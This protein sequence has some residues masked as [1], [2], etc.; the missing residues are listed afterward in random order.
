MEPSRLLNHIEN[1]ELVRRL[2][3]SS[4]WLDC[5]DWAAWGECSVSCTKNKCHKT[6]YAS[7]KG[8]EPWMI[9]HIWGIDDDLPR[10]RM[11]C[12][13]K[14]DQRWHPWFIR[15]FQLNAAARDWSKL[16]INPLPTLILP[17]YV[18]TSIRI[19]RNAIFSLFSLFA[20]ANILN[21]KLQHELL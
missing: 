13:P 5:A 8:A 21:L 15:I 1:A 16:I 10:W 11:V 4:H 14:I 6:N 17:R 3:V 12:H 2:F 7:G 9:Y 20:R 19:E 18:S